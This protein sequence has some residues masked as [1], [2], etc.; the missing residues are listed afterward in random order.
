MALS[1]THAPTDSHL[2]PRCISA[3]TL[4]PQLPVVNFTVSSQQ[5][6]C[7][8]CQPPVKPGAKGD[9][10]SSIYHW[11]RCVSLSESKSRS[12][13]AT[14]RS[15]RHRRASYTIVLDSLAGGKVAL[16]SENDAIAVRHSFKDASNHFSETSRRI[17]AA[18]TLRS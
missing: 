17:G 14:L 8:W 9:D 3:H 2:A 1:S 16:C 13:V 4:L 12:T 11:A 18:L 15:C 10:S 7:I 6:D 5:F